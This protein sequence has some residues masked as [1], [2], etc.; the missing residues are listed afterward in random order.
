MAVL[1]WGAQGESAQLEAQV[2][3]ALLEGDGPRAR[4]LLQRSPGVDDAF[5]SCVLAR[6]EKD[7]PVS[8]SVVPSPFTRR[9]L[10]AYRAA[11]RAGVMAAPVRPDASPVPRGAVRQASPS[12]EQTRAGAEARLLREVRGLLGHPDA[13]DLDALEP[14]ITSRLA[15]EGVSALMGRTGL[16]PELM[17]WTKEET[18]AEK[19][20]LPEGEEEVTVTRLD[21]FLSRG[22]GSDLTC[23]HSGT[24]GWTTPKALFAV[25]PAYDDLEGE[26]F[27]VNFLAHEAQHFA[28]LRRFPRLVPWEKEYRAKLV[29]L[30][31][32]DRTRPQVLRRF[33]TA[34]GDDVASP[35]GYANRRVLRALRAQLGLGPE[36]DLAVEDGARLRAAAREVLLADSATRRGSP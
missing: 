32:A 5:R 35:H 27:R 26:P 10:D 16:F 12:A 19:V 4:E 9:I 36:S 15:A 3:G 20:A 31:L 14:V 13:K 6:L 24:G 21:G 1:A 18:R 33:A 7:V 2:T 28:D 34:Q 23:G 30:S 11:W 22:W 17:L 25:V 8:A 29:E